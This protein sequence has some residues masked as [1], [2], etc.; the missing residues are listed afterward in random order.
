VGEL[1]EVS[2]R[3]ATT[4]TT[5]HNSETGETL[6]V[7]SPDWIGLNGRLEG[8]AEASILVAT[9]PSNPSAYAFELYG[10]RGTPSLTGRTPNSGPNILRGA[11]GQELAGMEVPD[12]FRLV[13]DPNLGGP[14]LN[15]AQAYVRLGDAIRSGQRYEPDFAHAVRRHLLIEAIERSS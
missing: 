14:A 13:P 3:L 15:V 2:A 8:G 4:I 10:T 12:R 9:V 7:D 1:A 5:W 11:R 6:Q